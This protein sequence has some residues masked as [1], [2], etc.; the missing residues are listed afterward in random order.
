MLGN[1]WPGILDAQVLAAKGRAAHRH[2]DGTALGR[3][4][5]RVGQEIEADLA[6]GALIGPELRQREIE[7]LDDLEA[8]VLGAKAHQ[9]TAISRDIGEGDRR[10]MQF[11]APGLDATDVE[12]LVDQIEQVLTAL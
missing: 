10:L 9:A 11:V 4:L 5:D 8:L 6:D 1:A 3:E 7:V 2:G 12:D